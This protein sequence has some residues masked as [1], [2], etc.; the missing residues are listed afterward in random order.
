M[1]D[2]PKTIRILEIQ[3]LLWSASCTWVEEMSSV[4]AYY[5][6]IFTGTLILFFDLCHLYLLLILLYNEKEIEKIL[7]ELRLTWSQ[8]GT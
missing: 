1:E 7:R 4:A 3:I 6:R 2:D 8:K 5:G